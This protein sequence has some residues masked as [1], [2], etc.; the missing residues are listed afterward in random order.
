MSDMKN[1]PEATGDD[2]DDMDDIGQLVR[3]AGERE[4]V[5]EERMA[6]ARE[7][8]GAHWQGVVDER[9]Q[10]RSLGRIQQLAIAASIVAVIGITVALWPAG[11]GTDQLVAVNRVSGDVMVDDRLVSAGDIFATHSTIETGDDGRI[12]LEF[13]DGQSVRL[14]ND[15]VLTVLASDHIELTAGGVYV[16]SGPL[17]DDAQITVATRLGKATDIGTQFQV[18][19]SDDQLLVGVREGLVELSRPDT[20]LLAIDSGNL[21]EISA[22]GA[23]TGRRIAGND[24]IWGW[25]T[26]ISPAFDIEGVTLESYLHWYSREAGLD[27]EWQDSASRDLARRTRLSGT[28]DGMALDDGLELVRR[29]A[30]FE[31]R[32]SDSRLHVSVE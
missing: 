12:A 21:F 17:S 19:L 30:P 26:A 7:R 29:I 28:I 25:V 16:D 14:D 27:L 5:D 32:L 4:S 20:A 13:P 8:V 24:P 1:T 2:L 23:E 22:G 31:S 11:P 18:R 10:K 3:F 15:T 6:R 9:R